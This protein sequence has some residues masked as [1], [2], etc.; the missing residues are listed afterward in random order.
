MSYIIKETATGVIIE[1]SSQ[2]ENGF[3]FGTGF[4][5]TPHYRFYFSGNNAKCGNKGTL[6]INPLSPTQVVLHL[7][8]EGSIIRVNCGTNYSPQNEATK[9]LLN[10]GLTLTKQ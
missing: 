3:I 1:D 2:I 7:Y 4:E 8:L 9:P 6:I 10:G 5:G